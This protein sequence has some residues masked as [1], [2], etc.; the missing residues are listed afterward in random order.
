MDNDYREPANSAHNHRSQASNSKKTGP[1]AEKDDI[2]NHTQSTP[3][4]RS[5]AQ[6]SSKF[7]IPR[8]HNAPRRPEAYRTPLTTT[9]PA[10]SCKPIRSRS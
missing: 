2:E 3:P 4:T 1:N 7:T 10:P 9:W 5:R 6:E 8:I